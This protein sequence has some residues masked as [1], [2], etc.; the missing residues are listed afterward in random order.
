MHWSDQA[1]LGDRRG[2][3]C[4]WSDGFCWRPSRQSP[5]SR[6]RCGGIRTRVD[7]SGVLLA[8]ERIEIQ[9]AGLA[10]EVPISWQQLDQEPAWSPTGDGEKRIGISWFH[11]VSGIRP[12]AVLLPGDGLIVASAPIALEWG[13][14]HQYDFSILRN[15]GSGAAGEG[16]RAPAVS[17]EIH[18]IITVA[19][20]ETQWAYDLHAVAPTE[21]EL[22]ALKPIL[23]TMLGSMHLTT[24]LPLGTSR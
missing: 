9:E 22:A 6:G 21:E 11:L 8:Y 10:L 24:P 18:M 1:R 2:R 3:G 23:D 15:S 5:W 4:L 19:D 13:A 20:G 12:E 14:G 7:L 16:A 17:L